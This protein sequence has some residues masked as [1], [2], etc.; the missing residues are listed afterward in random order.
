[1]RAHARLSPSSSKRWFACAGSVPLSDGEGSDPSE[2]SDNG[3]AM[4]TVAAQVLES[5]GDAEP[6]DAVGNTV[7]VSLPH[8]PLREVEFTE[9][10]AATVEGYV[11]AV[12]EIVDGLVLGVDWFIEQRV[13]FTRYV[14]PEDELEGLD[15]A[16][17]QF[18]TADLL[19]FRG[20]EMIVIDLKT[21]FKYVEVENNTQ[22]LFYALGAY[23]EHSL[24]RDIKTIRL[25]VY[26]P[27]HGGMHEW[28]LPV[29]EI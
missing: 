12:R 8:E 19:A 29:G 5:L 14:V 15:E 16:D 13:E 24:M 23:D 7:V 25:M 17:H 9:E 21:G 1:M 3:T 10:M 27:A 18:G 11:T 2:Y 28:V 22:E 26:Q 4:H 6:Y 20:D